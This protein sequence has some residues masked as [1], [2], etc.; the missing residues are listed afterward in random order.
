M[1]ACAEQPVLK[2][3]RYFTK[4]DPDAFERERLALLAQLA[5]PIT[6]QRLIRPAM[7]PGW[8]CLEAGAED[9]SV[10]SWLAPRVGPEGRLRTD[11][12]RRCLLGK[13][14]PNLEVRRHD[15]LA[16]DL[17]MDCL[18]P[19]WATAWKMTGW[20]RFVLITSD[21]RFCKKDVLDLSMFS[22]L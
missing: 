9:G 12:D 1:S 8:G 14:L 5:D 21:Y 20:F 10:V 22:A 11:L 18:L 6:T 3:A 15:I 7:G 4:D 2:G 13:L 17:A 19:A 16:D